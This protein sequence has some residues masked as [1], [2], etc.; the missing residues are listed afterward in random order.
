MVYALQKFRHYLL[1]K[2]FKMFTDHLALKYLVNMPV[3]GGG[4]YQWL[5]LF[6]EFYFEV[7]VKPG[8]SNAGPNHLSRVTNGEEPTN[9][10]ENFPDAQLFSVHIVDEYFADIIQYLS[11]CTAPH[12]YNTAQKKNMVVQ[13]A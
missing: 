9:L 5:L 10:E 2:H 13:A 7:I 8:K 6:Q 12:E 4:I 1:G 11:T 3:L